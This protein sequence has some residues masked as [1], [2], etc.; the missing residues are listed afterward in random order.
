MLRNFSS[1]QARIWSR[2]VPVLV[3]WL[4]AAKNFFSAAKSMPTIEVTS[5]KSLSYSLSRVLCGTCGDET[6]AAPADDKLKLGLL[7]CTPLES[8]VL[9]SLAMVLGEGDEGLVNMCCCCCCCCCSWYWCEY[10]WAGSILIGDEMLPRGE[11]ADELP[12]ADELG[13]L[14]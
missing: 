14:I 2:L 5:L 13:R 1:L 7:M 9:I 3:E 10:C 11:A 4:D 12:D 6:L 8:S